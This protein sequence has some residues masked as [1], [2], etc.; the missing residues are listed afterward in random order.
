MTFSEVSPF[1]TVSLREVISCISQNTSLSF[2]FFS[3]V[4]TTTSSTVSS[5]TPATFVAKTASTK[6][7]LACS[8]IIS[9]RSAAA[10]FSISSSFADSSILHSATIEEIGILSLSAASSD[11]NIPK[12]LA[13]I[14][15]TI[16]T[17]IRTTKRTA[18]PPRAARA[19]IIVFVAAATI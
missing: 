18:H 14:A 12:G 1:V 7:Q 16:I 4:M 2:C 17:T 13:A 3:S 15:A 19:D 8:P 11:I 9:L 6:S 10:A 5:S